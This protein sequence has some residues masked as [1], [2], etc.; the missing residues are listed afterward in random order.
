MTTGGQQ[1]TSTVEEGRHSYKLQ[2]SLNSSLDQTGQDKQNRTLNKQQAPNF[3]FE[4]DE[5]RT[6][7]HAS[8]NAQDIN[9]DEG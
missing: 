1:E 5:N 6:S 8:E 9:E 7:E 4:D 2:D 3:I